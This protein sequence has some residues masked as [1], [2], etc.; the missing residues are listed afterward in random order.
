MK[1]RLGFVTNSSSSSFICEICGEIESGWDITLSEANMHTC[2][3]GH[4]ICDSHMYTFVPD[5]KKLHERFIKEAR[6]KLE[7]ILDNEEDNCHVKVYRYLSENNLTIDDFLKKDIEE[8]EEVFE[9]TFGWSA[10]TDDWIEDYEY[11]SITKDN[12][13]ALIEEKCPICMHADATESQIM[14]FALQKLGVTYEELKELTLKA[15]REEE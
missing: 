3:N 7:D 15:L 8:I 4:T 10:A 12:R 5:E 1:K 6:K 9:H 2:E 11:V 14:K 13:Y